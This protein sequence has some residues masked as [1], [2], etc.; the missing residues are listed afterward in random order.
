MV[1]ESLT[2]IAEA[3]AGGDSAALTRYFA[4]IQAQLEGEGYFGETLGVRIVS[5]AI[6]KISM[7]MPHNKRVLRQGD[8]FHGGAV[9]G[10]ADHASGCAF[11]SDPRVVAGGMAGVSTD[12][13]ASFLRR[14]RPDEALIANANVIRRGRS[15]TFVSVSVCG[16]SSGDEILV[17]RATCAGLAYTRVGSWANA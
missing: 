5:F 4:H 17:A 10:F 2:A 7:R 14:S 15:I 11:L 12:F 1:E 6:D 8:I 16:E 3:A 9:M 13:N